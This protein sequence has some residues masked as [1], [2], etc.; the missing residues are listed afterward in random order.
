MPDQPD[1]VKNL[2]PDTGR[3]FRRRTQFYVDSDGDLHYVT[4]AF[5][6]QV[7]GA[8]SG[9]AAG[10]AGN[11]WVPFGD[12][13]TGAPSAPG[14]QAA[15]TADGGYQRLDDRAWPTYAH[16]IEPR[17]H[18]VVNAGKG[19]DDTAEAL[20]RFD[21][22]VTPHSPTVVTI[23]IGRNDNDS[24]VLTFDST[25]YLRAMSQE[26]LRGIVAKCRLAG[27]LPVLLTLPPT[28]RPTLP[29][30]TPR[31]D[32]AWRKWLGVYAEANNIPLI[33]LPEATVDP[34][35]GK[36][37]SGLGNDP[38]GADG[39]HPTP[40]GAKAIADLVAAKLGPILP[41]WAPPLPSDE[42]GWGGNLF[43]TPLISGTTGSGRPSGS[44]WSESQTGGLGGITWDTVTNDTAIKGSWLR[45]TASSTTGGS[46][47]SIKA[48][49]VPGGVTAG[50]RL[51]FVARVKQSGFAGT[52][53]WSA[54]LR[55]TGGGL[56][57]PNSD[58]GYSQ[59]TQPCTSGGICAFECVVPSVATG[60]QIQ[61]RIDVATGAS[62]VAQWAQ[63][64]L[65][66]LTTL[67]V[68][69]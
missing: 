62:G 5:G 50:H 9:G 69:A 11:R 66:D 49:T 2:T 60:L 32:A 31:R 10:L 35:T 6:D 13:L 30:D 47:S 53:K 68:A 51:R 16:I 46:G 8:S 23:L 29:A 34:A 64:G 1:F 39:V 57:S 59:L 7:A 17:L 33:D 12:S 61:I 58:W 37:I 63:L 54:L 18:M 38:G 3:S 20:A 67:G 42:Q 43:T 4:P 45:V 19:G 21:S 44:G 48:F 25:T 27:A 65:Y 24:A 55:F 22:H 28:D 14:Y 41:P 36:W 15:D 56:T 40:A 52:F 26:N